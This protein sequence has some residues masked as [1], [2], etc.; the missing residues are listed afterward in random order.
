MKQ[1]LKYLPIL[2][3]LAPLFLGGCTNNGGGIDLVQ[4]TKNPIVQVIIGLVVLWFVF[5][6]KGGK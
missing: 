6:G 2:F 3:L 1:R 4:L 5:K